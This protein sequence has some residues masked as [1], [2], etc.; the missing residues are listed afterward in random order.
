MGQPIFR[1]T[2]KNSFCK[3]LQNMNSQYKQG[4]TLTFKQQFAKT[5]VKKKTRSSPYPMVSRGKGSVSLLHGA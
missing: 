4:K 2:F 3:S 1:P 5:K